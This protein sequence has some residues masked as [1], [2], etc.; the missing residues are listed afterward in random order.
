MRNIDYRRYYIPQASAEFQQTLSEGNCDLD[1][2]HRVRE[3]V[4]YL[5]TRELQPNE[6]YY[7]VVLRTDIVRTWVATCFALTNICL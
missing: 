4:A 1:E 7:R 6:T 3:S 2:L 5:Y